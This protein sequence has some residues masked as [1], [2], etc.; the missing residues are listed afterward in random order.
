MTTLVPRGYGAF[1][2]FQ[3]TSPNQM[4]S[5]N[6]NDRS[7]RQD[8]YFSPQYTSQQF[9]PPHSYRD[10]F[11]HAGNQFMS[12]FSQLDDRYRYEQ[13]MRRLAKVE[14]QYAKLQ[15]YGD[16]GPMYPQATIGLHNDPSVVYQYEKET[17]FVPIPVFI[18]PN[19]GAYQYPQNLGFGGPS[20]N[21]TYPLGGGM[22]VLPKVRVIFVPTGPSSFQQPYTGPLV[23][24]RFKS[25]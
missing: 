11:A 9:Y 21:L 10:K 3:F 16:P 4:I 8:T 12:Y 1:P 2:F 19:P 6:Y 23:S 20:G 7:T 18:N 5:Q 15:K 14:K 13:Y 22:N 17:K 25:F 24:Y